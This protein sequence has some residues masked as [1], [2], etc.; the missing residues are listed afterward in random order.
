M[1]KN[2]L[3]GLCSDEVGDDHDY[4]QCDLCKKW[5]LTRCLNIGAKKYKKL[6]TIHIPGAAQTIQ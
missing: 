2:F 3:C 5:N 6:K 1:I 4:V